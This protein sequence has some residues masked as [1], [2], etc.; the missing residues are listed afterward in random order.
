MA[1]AE[2]EKQKK[3][4]KKHIRAYLAD[5][6]EQVVGSDTAYLPSVIALNE[7]LREPNADTLLDRDLKNQMRDLWVKLKST[8]IQLSDPPL[9]FGLP[10]D[11]HSEEEEIVEDEEVLEYLEQSEK[12]LEQSEKEESAAQ[13]QA[14]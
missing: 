1:K 3:F 4:T 10:E 9:L 8:G 5:I 7:I 13:N 6:E 12:D 2:Q 14:E 11:F